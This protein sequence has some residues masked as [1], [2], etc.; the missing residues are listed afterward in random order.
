[1]AQFDLRRLRLR[2]G[3]EHRA[4]VEIQLEPVAL[5]GMRYLPVPER[6][7]AELVVTRASTGT[8][9]QLRFRARL[10]G[11]CFRCLEDAVVE[12]SI[13]AREYQA[14]NPGDSDELQTPYLEDDLVDLERWARDALVLSLPDKILCEPDCPGLCPTCGKDLKGEPHEHDEEPGDPRWGVL[15]ELKD[16]L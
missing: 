7:P 4:E 12:S 5:G 3:D 6:V 9:L 2:S 13:A 15:A 1:M 11:S 16:Q 8:V 14:T 10:H